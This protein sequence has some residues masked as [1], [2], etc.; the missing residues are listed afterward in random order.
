M[1]LEKDVYNTHNAWG[2]YFFSCRNVSFFG[3]HFLT[4]PCNVFL[5]IVSFHFPHQLLPSLTSAASE[6]DC[7]FAVVDPVSSSP[8]LPSQRLRLSY[9][10]LPLP[11]PCW[12]SGSALFYLLLSTWPNHSLPGLTW[13][14]WMSLWQ[15]T[16]SGPKE[17]PCWAKT[18]KR[19]HYVAVCGG[20]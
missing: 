13:L 15:P 18:S 10:H 1:Y 3:F 4:L 20:W 6:A 7:S 2:W 11:H 19:R 9:G 5:F 17:T 16:V 8:P 14:H 12:N